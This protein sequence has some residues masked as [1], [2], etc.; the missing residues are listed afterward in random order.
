MTPRPPPETG[1]LP[2]RLRSARDYGERPRFCY[3]HRLPSPSGPAP[4]R[5]LGRAQQAGAA[6]P[7]RHRFTSRSPRAGL[8]TNS[9]SPTPPGKRGVYTISAPPVA[10][11]RPVPI[12]PV[13]P[14]RPGLAGNRHAQGGTWNECGS[15]T[16]RTGMSK[17]GLM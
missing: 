11:E 17:I 6:R 16:S 5:P 2:V 13:P 8:P 4:A 12:I 14:F 3:L 7:S 9:R 1:I 15:R 10:F